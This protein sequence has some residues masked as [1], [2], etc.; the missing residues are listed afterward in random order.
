RGESTV[1]S[2]WRRQEALGPG[3]PGP[4]P[5]CVPPVRSPAPGRLHFLARLRARCARGRALA[6]VPD[7]RE[8]SARRTFDRYREINVGTLRR[9]CQESWRNWPARCSQE[10]L[11]RCK[12]R[13]SSAVPSLG[14]GHRLIS[15]YF[16][17]LPILLCEE[18]S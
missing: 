1:R 7:A 2:G 12:L 6:H 18:P 14:W 5:S 3:P 17:D 13:A 8:L 9:A 15:K 16:E 4:A 11:A 10:G